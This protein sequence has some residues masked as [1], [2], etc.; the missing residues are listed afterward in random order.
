M[1]AGG[2]VKG[3][4]GWRRPGKV[5][6]TSMG[7]GGVL[8]SGS[9]DEVQGRDYWGSA[10]PGC[11]RKSLDPGSPRIC[12]TALPRALMHQRTSEL[13]ACSTIHPPTEPGCAQQAA[14][15][16]NAGAE[17]SGR[18]SVP[19]RPGRATTPS[20]TA[21]LHARGGGGADGGATTKDLLVR[22]LP[23]CA[24]AEWRHRIT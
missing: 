16:A 3:S 14:S 15:R 11:R 1:K 24:A 22:R 5:L 4:S 2:P 19:R 9:A 13:V 7:E 12:R 20:G 18:C 17:T 10:V 23:P 21:A 6:E 8:R